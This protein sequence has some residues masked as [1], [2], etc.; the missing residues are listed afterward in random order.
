MPCGLR[1]IA[2]T[3]LLVILL[4]RLLSFSIARLLFRFINKVDSGRDKSSFVD[5]YHHRRIYLA[6][7]PDHGFHRGLPAV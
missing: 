4:K 7:I 5:H 2:G 6:I 1:I 3:I